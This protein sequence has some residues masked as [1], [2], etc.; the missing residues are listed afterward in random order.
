MQ[1]TAVETG[2]VSAESDANN[3]RVNLV[4][5]EGGNSYSGEIAYFYTNNHS[6]EREPQRRFAVARRHEPQQSPEP[7]RLERHARR[8]G[9]AKTSSGSSRRPRFAG[10]KNQVQGIYFNSTQGTPFYTPDLDRPG[11][12][13]S[14]INSQAGRITWQATPKQKISGFLDMQNFQVRGVGDN[15]ALEAQTR[16]NFWPS[17]LLQATWTSPRTSK[18]LLEAGFSATLQP[19]SGNLEETPTI[20]GSR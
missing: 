15:K 8:A 7:Q 19:L 1:E 5:K 10:T 18:L 16:W 4:P 20:S 11:F 17:M 9:Q 3:V 6:A 2:G 14:S 13:D 12:R